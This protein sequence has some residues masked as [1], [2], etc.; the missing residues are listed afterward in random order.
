MRKQSDTDGT[1]PETTASIRRRSDVGTRAVGVSVRLRPQELVRLDR[2]RENVRVETWVE[3]M[4]RSQAV[5]LL[6]LRGLPPDAEP[7]TTTNVVPLRRPTCQRTLKCS[8][9]PE[10]AGA[11]DD[12]G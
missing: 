8:Q 5:R 1:R 12:L 6:V 2:F 11:C 4:T 3:P 7:A 10:H 9:S